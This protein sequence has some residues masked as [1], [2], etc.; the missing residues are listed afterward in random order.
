MKMFLTRLGEHSRM[1]VTGDPSQTDLERGV[2]SGLQ[3]ALQRLR[4]FGDVGMV[5]FQPGDVVRHPLVEQIVRAYM[6][7]SRVEA[8]PGATP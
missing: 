8:E 1:V 6:A 2:R 4:G 7:P 3:D 5:Q